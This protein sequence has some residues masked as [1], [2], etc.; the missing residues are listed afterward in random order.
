M[1]GKTCLVTGASSGIGYETALGLARA[2]AR[3]IL[4]GRDGERSR[5]AA[6]AITGST[7]NESID[8]LLA[9]LSERSQVLRLAEAVRANYERLDVLVNNAGA[10]FMQ[11]ELS[12]DGLERTWALNHLAYFLLSLELLD[13][14]MASA[15]AR[16]VNVASNLHQAGKIDFADPNGETHYH[17]MRSYCQSK[18]ANVMFSYALARR[19]AGSGV[20]VNCLHPGSV[21]TGIGRDHQGLL[22]RASELFQPFRLSPEQGARTT[23]WAACSP[24]L[25]EVS[26]KYFAKSRFA[27]SSRASHDLAAQERLWQLSLAQTG[28][29]PAAEPVPI[30]ALEG[31]PDA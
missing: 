4:V 9:D 7:G 2:G 23:L 10:Y 13:L 3:V 5:A 14:L 19:L 30:I 17:G 25:A 22:R 16:I 6:E 27:R 28:H 29:M 21:A 20:T 31:S 8:V 18:L 12:R 15:P 11:R 24:A 26:G 1:Q